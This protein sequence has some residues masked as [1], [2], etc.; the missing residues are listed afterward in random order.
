M[1][2]HLEVKPS[3]ALKGAYARFPEPLLETVHAEAVLALI[4]LERAHEHPM[5]NSAF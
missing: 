1:R 4:A 5:A 2:L 3:F